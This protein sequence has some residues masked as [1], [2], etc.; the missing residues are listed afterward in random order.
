LFE[1]RS[2]LLPKR[3]EE[4]NKMGESGSVKNTLRYRLTKLIGGKHDGKILRIV[5]FAGSALL[6]LLGIIVGTTVHNNNHSGLR[7]QQPTDGYDDY[8]WTELSPNVQNAAV[9]LGWNQRSWDMDTGNELYMNQW[10]ELSN[11]HKTAATLLGYNKENWCTTDD[12]AYDN[13]ESTEVPTSVDTSPD[14]SPDT[15]SST[16]SGTSSDTASDTG[17]D[18][19][20]DTSSDTEELFYRDYDWDELSTEAKD[21]ASKFGYTTA[22]QWNNEI[23]FDTDWDDLNDELRAAATLLGYTKDTWC[24][25]EGGTDAPSDEET[26]EPSTSSPTEPATATDM[27]DEDW[28]DLPNNIKNAAIQL[29][30]NQ[31]MWDTQGDMPAAIFD[32]KWDQLTEEQKNAASMVF[33]YNESIW[34]YE[35]SESLMDKINDDVWMDLTPEIQQAASILGYDQN[36]WDNADNDDNDRP[37]PPSIT[38][39]DWTE[40]TEEQKQA[41]IILGWNEQTWCDSVDQFGKY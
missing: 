24:L 13:D 17:S 32:K 18:T 35:Y 7:G 36:S 27:S 28:I 15:S 9:T 3:K 34:E 31:E 40:L 10:E 2:N 41:A 38:L 39:V 21:A 6:L 25:D 26:D 1:P 23:E 5:C 11:E 8:D 19:A 22:T 30:Y 14:T 37:E 16:S 29:G 33:G 20:S 4:N 12:D